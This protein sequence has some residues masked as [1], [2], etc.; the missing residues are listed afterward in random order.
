MQSMDEVNVG[1]GQTVEQA[2]AA[3]GPAMALAAARQAEAAAFITDHW[4]QVVGG[5]SP[6]VAGQDQRGRDAG[7]A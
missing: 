1:I 5:H 6:L 2:R 3:L 7:S 4:H